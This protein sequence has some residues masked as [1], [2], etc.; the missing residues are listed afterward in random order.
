MP[1]SQPD[2]KAQGTKLAQDLQ[3]LK[4]SPE[5]KA[6]MVRYL[7][8]LE[9]A[10]KRLLFTLAVFGVTALLAGL[11]YKRIIVFV[12]ARFDLQ[13]INMVLT[14]PFQVIELAI[15]IGLFMGILITL[16]LF[17]YNLLS[18]LKPA[19]EKKE[20]QTVAGMVPMGFALFLAGFFFGIWVMNFVVA[21]F[22]KSSLEFSIGNIWDVGAF[23]SQMIFTGLTMGLMFQ[24]P[25]AITLTI[26][27]DLVKHEFFVKNRPYVYVLALVIA[28]LLPPT[29]IFSLVILV[30]PLFFLFEIALYINKNYQKT[31]TSSSAPIKQSKITQSP[32]TSQRT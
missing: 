13:G 4:L 15:N 28:A 7:P 11:N 20:Y 25:I 8:Y 23:F 17:T 30:L 29:D 26:R 21:V 24:F 10:Q 18:F 32:E 31:D 22:T 2:P 1:Q 3:N 9:E 27:L 14:S 5:T 12:L 6:A 19:L 16:P